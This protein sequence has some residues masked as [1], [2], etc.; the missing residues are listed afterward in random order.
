[1]C[2][3]SSFELCDGVML[4]FMKCT[5]SGIL[6]DGQKSSLW[7]IRYSKIFVFIHLQN[8]HFKI[9]ISHSIQWHVLPR[10]V[11]R[12]AVCVE[13]EGGGHWKARGSS[14]EVLMK[15]K[16]PFPPDCVTGACRGKQ[17]Q[18]P[19]SIQ[20]RSSFGPEAHVSRA[21]LVTEVARSNA[22]SL[23]KYEY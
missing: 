6:I 18:E 21:S 10:N 17:T 14:T 22:S 5:C 15:K 4:H 7:I 12:C 11:F 1:M 2:G 9:Q 20:K 13:R 8:V 16:M 19:I 3:S 23:H